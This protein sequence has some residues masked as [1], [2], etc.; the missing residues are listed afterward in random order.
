M[1]DIDRVEQLAQGK[2][3]IM[4]LYRPLEAQ[5]GTS[6]LQAV[7][8]GRACRCQTCVPTFEHMGAKVVD[9]RPY[10]ITPVDGSSAWLYD[11]GLRCA[12]EDVE[13][14]RD[15]FQE[16]FLAARRGELEDDA[17]NGLVLRAA[18]TG[19]EI[20]VVRAVAKY[21][22]QA[23]IA[24]SDAYM[25]RTLL[26]HADIAALLVKLFGARFDPDGPRRRARRSG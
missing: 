1:S 21:L 10:Q 22:R 19:R 20:T 13:R 8:L 16:A 2:G 23:G 5:V 24:F 7:Q 12:A 14:V 4:S 17:L 15:I 3:P 6:A 11:F 9:E 18:L 26:G 25:E